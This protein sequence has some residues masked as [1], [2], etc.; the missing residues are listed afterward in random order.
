MTAQPDFRTERDLAALEL[1]A[2]RLH[3]IVLSQCG[4]KAPGVWALIEQG[5]RVARDV[6]AA[7]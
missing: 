6:M 1:A 3:Q 7:N 4:S 2:S 5:L